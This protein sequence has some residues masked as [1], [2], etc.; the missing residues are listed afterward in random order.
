MTKKKTEQQPEQQPET[1]DELTELD[2][3]K[4]PETT[5]ETGDYDPAA[6]EAQAQEL[7]VENQQLQAKAHATAMV[8]VAVIEST[9]SMLYPGVTIAQERKTA[10]AQKLAPVQVKYQAGGLPPWLAKYQ[11]ELE[12][13]GV[14]GMVGFSVY[15]QVKAGAAKDVTPE[16]GQDGKESEPEAA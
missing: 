11:E 14:V 15:Q 13:L 5:D 3:L 4:E 9:I 6:D 7:A 16:G 10:V 12:L 1:T 2:N 8:S